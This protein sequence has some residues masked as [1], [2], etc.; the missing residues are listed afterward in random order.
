MCTNHCFNTT[1]VFFLTKHSPS[2]NECYSRDSLL[3]QNFESYLRNTFWKIREMIL[4]K[5]L[6]NTIK[7]YTIKNAWK[8]KTLLLLKVVWDLESLFWVLKSEKDFHLKLNLMGSFWR[9]VFM[10]NGKLPVF[11]M[12]RPETFFYWSQSIP[13]FENLKGFEWLCFGL[14]TCFTGVK[15]E[16]RVWKNLFLTIL[17]PS[18]SLAFKHILPFN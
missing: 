3:E 16:C 18:T 15:R 11:G 2:N 6:E 13:N 1:F 5:V 9:F 10:M 7:Y 14:H 4:L 12:F 17:N 8:L